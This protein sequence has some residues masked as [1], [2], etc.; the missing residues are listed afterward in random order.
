QP[1]HALQSGAAP[2]P[3]LTYSSESGMG[4]IL[5]ATRYAELERIATQTPVTAH[6]A[7]VLRTLA[8][9]GRGIAWLPHSL[10]ADDLASHRLLPAA[11]ADWNVELEIRV[12]RDRT[13]MGRSA[14]ALWQVVSPA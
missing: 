12:F 8:L 2:V 10:I 1:R 6:L 13:P 4:Q 9:D 14:E 7:S 11:A 5:R 3:L